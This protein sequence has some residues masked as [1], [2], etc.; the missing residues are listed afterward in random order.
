MKRRI[1]YC[2]IHDD[3]AYIGLP[4][5]ATIQSCLDLINKIGLKDLNCAYGI[6]EIVEKYSQDQY[7]VKIIQVLKGTGIDSKDN[8]GKTTVYHEIWIELGKELERRGILPSLSAR[9][10]ESAFERMG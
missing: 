6:C 3:R 4:A 1:Y 10:H 5:K 2:V 8:E 7:R 9:L